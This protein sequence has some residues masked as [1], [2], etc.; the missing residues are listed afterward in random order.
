MPLDPISWAI[1]GFVVGVV[2]ASFWDE[3]TE[4]ANRALESILRTID[5]A[6]TVTSDAVV[7]LTKKGTRVYKKI[8]VYARNIYNDTTKRHT[9][10]EEVSKDE[11]PDDINQKLQRKKK[12]KLMQQTT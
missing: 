11:I 3:I 6:V 9:K 8:E 4:W 10:K 2:A 5:L 7:Y 12:L 1:I